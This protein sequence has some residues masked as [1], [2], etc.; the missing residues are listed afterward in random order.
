[1]PPLLKRQDRREIPFLPGDSYLV[2]DR[3]LD[4]R[5]PRAVF[6]TC[7]PVRSASLPLAWSWQ[8]IRSETTAAI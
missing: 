3:N 2:D 4:D 7:Y 8:P 5:G 6:P 1:M